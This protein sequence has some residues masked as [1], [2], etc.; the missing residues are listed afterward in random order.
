ME[1]LLIRLLESYYRAEHLPWQLE[2][3][4][5]GLFFECID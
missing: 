4:N 1:V 2:P 3:S 5:L